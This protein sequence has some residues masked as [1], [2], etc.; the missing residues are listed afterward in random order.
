[1]ILLREGVYYTWGS[2]EIEGMLCHVGPHREA[3]GPARDRGNERKTRRGALLWFLWEEMSEARWA[4]LRL[5]AL[6]NFSG[7]WG[8]GAALPCLAPG[9]GVIR[10]DGEWPGVSGPRGGGWAHGLWIGWRAFERRAPRARASGALLF[11][12]KTLE[13]LVGWLRE[14]QF[15]QGHQG[16]KMSKFQHSENKK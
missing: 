12:E 6:S 11:L 13:E 10:A 4:G 8:I 16:A 15:L 14:G 5:I 1:M 2:L 7:P 9:P 3:P